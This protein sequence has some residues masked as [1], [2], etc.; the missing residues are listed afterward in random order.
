MV[1]ISYTT[2]STQKIITNSSLKDPEKI[3]P[4]VID[5]LSNNI[6]SPNA[7]DAQLTKIQSQ[8]TFKDDPKSIVI[9]L[10]HAYF[11]DIKVV[12]SVGNN[13]VSEMDYVNSGYLIVT[14]D[15]GIVVQVEEIY[16]ASKMV[17]DEIGSAIAK[18]NYT[19]NNKTKVVTE[20]DII[21]WKFKKIDSV[22][23]Y[24]FIYEFFGFIIKSGAIV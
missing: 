19:E 1:P 7:Y 2:E 20:K 11:G 9:S 15:T 10:E 6:M 18:L 8:R 3:D 24:E 5:L 12:G 4:S 13:Q 22:M 21:F 23:Q 16:N 17:S 14:N